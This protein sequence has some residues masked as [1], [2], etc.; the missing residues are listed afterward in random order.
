MNGE[1]DKYENTEQF[2]CGKIYNNE[3]VFD[4]YLYPN[5]KPNNGKELCLI[6]L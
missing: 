1:Q 2:F 5:A 4:V 3:A 6:I